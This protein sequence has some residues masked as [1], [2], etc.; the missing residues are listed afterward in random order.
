[1]RS[2]TLKTLALMLVVF[3][4]GM[5]KSDAEAQANSRPGGAVSRSSQLP[6]IERKNGIA[7]LIVDGQPYLM[8]AG[9]L[10]NSSASS[11]EYMRP[12]W[13]KLVGLHLNTVIGTVSWELV[14]PEEGKF[15]FTTVD[16]EIREARKHGL[17]LVL[18]WFGA[19]K[20]ASSSYAPMWVKLDSARFPRAARQSGSRATSSFGSAE[21]A[22]SPFSDAAVGEDAKAF[23]ALMQHIRTTDLRHTVMMVQVENEVGVLGTSRDSSPITDAAWSKPV[24]K[25]LM[26]YLILHKDSLLPELDSIWAL[27]GYKK[28]GSWAEVFGT[29]A[30]SD[31]VFMSW[32]FARAVQRIAA[33]GKQI[34]PIPMYVNAWLGP[35]PGQTTPGQYPSGGPVA[36]M[37]DVWRAAAPDI[38]LFAPDIYIADFKGVCS[39]YVRSGNPLFFPE[40]R[41]SVPNY[42]WAVGQENALGISPFG[43]EDLASNAQ[44]AGANEALRG[45]APLILKNRLDG[46]VMTV[47]EDDP[48]A[49]ETFEKIT[50]L[51]IRFRGSSNETMKDLPPAP[52]NDSA[53][54]I[55]PEKDHRGFVLLVQTGPSEFIVAGSG[56]VVKNAVARLGSIDEM[57][58]RD[59]RLVE[60]RRF[61]GDERFVDNLFGLSSEQIQVRK[62]VTYT[63]P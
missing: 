22:L 1:M 25:E 54:N 15:D 46:K 43:V 5:P 62:I 21:N 47:M 34:L 50:G 23:R 11:S 61:N 10:H 7:Q 20:N 53:A 58:L 30:G 59:D 29:N 55:K 33:A 26:D 37:L 18:I 19:W 49:A 36:G 13:D 39:K 51:E 3:V 4:L 32:A 38:D 48:A 35:Q 16:D 28:S 24:P 8:V 9:E 31:E 45:L 41:P 42:F 56:A 63:A 27:S 52:T 14:E 60:G 12:I 2:T 57:L 17:R 44:L 6:R 40:S